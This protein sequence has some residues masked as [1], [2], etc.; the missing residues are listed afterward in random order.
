MNLPTITTPRRSARIWVSGL[1]AALLVAVLNGGWYLAT[2]AAGVDYLVT[3]PGQSGEQKLPLVVLVV[4]SIVSVLLG[5][6]GLCL[7]ARVAWGRLV[8]TVLVILAY[9][10]S[11]ASPITGAR[12]ISTVVCLVVAHTTVAAAA[13]LGPGRYALAPRRTVGQGVVSP[14]PGRDR[15]HH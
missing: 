15:L 4:V 14:A 9:A 6:A 8:W 13:L 1:S 10:L 3:P 7:L 11:L 12:Q 2:R 5:T